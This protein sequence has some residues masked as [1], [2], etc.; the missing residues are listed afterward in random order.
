M[1]I[2][3]RYELDDF[4]LGQGGMGAVY[5]GH[6]K[7]LDRKVAVKFLHLPG[8][9]DDELERRFMREARILALGAGAS[10][11]IAGLTLWAVLADGIA[12]G[13]GTVPLAVLGLTAL[14]AFEIVAHKFDE[15]LVILLTSVKR[16]VPVAINSPIELVEL[17]RI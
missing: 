16:A 2:G 12:A 5:G 11:L 10:T 17:K 14:T 8:G 9:P 6:D 4:P 13:L 3:D 1:V 7:H 15:L